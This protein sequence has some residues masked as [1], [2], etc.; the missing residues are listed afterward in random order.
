MNTVLSLEMFTPL[1][2]QR[3]LIVDDAGTEYPVMLASASGSRT[4]DFPGRVRD[5]FQLQFRS[6]D[7]SVHGFLAQQTYV[8]KHGTLGVLEMFLVPIGPPKDGSGG[9]LYQSVFT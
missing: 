9:F 4:V 1:M 8:V 6:E 3:F 2:G 7:H 5:P